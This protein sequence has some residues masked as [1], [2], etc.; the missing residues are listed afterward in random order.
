M[1]NFLYQIFN[2]IELLLFRYSFEFTMM[3]DIFLVSQFSSHLVR[4][5]RV[6]SL[7]VDSSILTNNLFYSAGASDD[8]IDIISHFISL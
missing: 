4:P 1:P 8:F 5:F 2:C 7:F 3:K 6:L